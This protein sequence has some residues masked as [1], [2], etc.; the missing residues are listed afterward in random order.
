MHITRGRAAIGAGILLL[1]TAL[2]PLLAL[3]PPQP[4]QSPSS[5]DTVQ[6][7]SRPGFNE[8]SQPLGSITE[9]DFF[10]IY[11]ES[12]GKILT[13]SD[14]DFL[15]GA[16]VCEM[17]LSYSD[18][19][20]KAQAVAAYTVYD[21]QRAKRREAG[22]DGADFTCNTAT[23]WLYTTKEE[24]KSRW[25]S[26]YEMYRSRLDTIFSGL[27]GQRLIYHGE[28][29]LA[30]YSAISSGISES[31]ANIWGGALDYLVPVDSSWDRNAAGYA[32]EVTVSADELRSKL[33]KISSD[34]K[35][36]GDPAG[37]IGNCVRTDSGTVQKIE[38]GSAVFTGEQMR[39]AFALRSASFTLTYAD[40]AFCFQVHGYG[41]G[42]GMS[43]YGANYLA[44]QG[45]NYT[46]I[47]AH[48][49]PGTELISS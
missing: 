18:E 20:L 39:S 35:M 34:C 13:V 15:V 9:I 48:Y 42:V 24:M 33:Q 40:N 45:A 21:Y 44:Q 19:A 27:V 10:T 3:E 28:R 25:G 49:Y 16:V 43:Q 32:T 38:I 12:S 47:L 26:N 8:S 7:N 30:V 41:H 1:A 2:L 14:D 22:T 11:D 6:N 4:E 5:V 37:W 17:P 23:W 29:V 31:S 36:S 46:Q